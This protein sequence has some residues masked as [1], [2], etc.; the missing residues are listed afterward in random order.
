MRAAGDSSVSYFDSKARAAVVRAFEPIMGGI[1]LTGKRIDKNI[2]LLQIMTLLFC[3]ATGIILVY[4]GA[5]EAAVPVFAPL[6]SKTL[7]IDPGHG[8]ADGGAVASDG[9]KESA[10]NLAIS[11]KMKALS[12]L[13]GLRSVI[14]RESEELP[15]PDEADTIAQKKR[16]DQNARLE[17]IRSIDNAVLISIHQNYYPDPRPFG[18]QVLYGA[19][20]GSDELG[21]LCHSEL[22]RCICPENRRVAAPISEKI[23]LIRCAGCP[24][25][26]VECGFM[27]NAGELKKLLDADYQK[28][29]AVTILASYMNW[30]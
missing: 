17:E 7:I 21:T 29:I 5:D 24:A 25:I 19:E 4:Q 10:I 1:F 30:I 22:N 8:G 13:L 16:W 11:L 26:L 6:D 28:K 27:S 2:L 14:L 15:Y 20:P 3:F 23:F 9:T 12:D 18:P